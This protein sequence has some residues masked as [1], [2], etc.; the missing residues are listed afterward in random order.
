M[1]SYWRRLRAFARSG[2]R[3]RFPAGSILGHEARGLVG[4]LPEEMPRHLFLEVLAGARVGE[5][6]A[7]LVHQHLLV[8]EPPLPRFLGDALVEALAELARI[9]RIVEAFGLALE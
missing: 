1:C 8:L 9:G 6:Q 3:S 7:V 4:A 2:A 5:V